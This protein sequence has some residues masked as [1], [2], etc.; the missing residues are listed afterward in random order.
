MNGSYFCVTCNSHFYCAPAHHVCPNVQNYINENTDDLSS[1]C[2]ICG[3]DHDLTH[4]EFDV[5]SDCIKTSSIRIGYTPPDTFQAMWDQQ[6]KFMK[7]LQKERSFPTFPVDI[8]SKYGQKIIKDIS[9]DCMH[10][11]FE[12]VHLLRNSKNHR[13][14]E[15][16]KFDREAFLEEL[17]DVLHFFLEI[18]ILSGITL[19][20][21]VKAYVDKG[22][23]NTKRINDGY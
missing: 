12:A 8:T 2:S 21:L 17:S 13:K 4:H 14:T 5:C 15:I 10:E 3:K 18:C 11:L 7:L 20:E 22:N 16:T 6:S 1:K 9:H 19:D 23:V